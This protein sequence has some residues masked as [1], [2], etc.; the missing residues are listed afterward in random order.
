VIA[1][2]SAGAGIGGLLLGI[3]LILLLLH[4]LEKRRH[5][6]NN[7][8]LR[9]PNIPEMEDEDQNLSLVKWFLRGK[10]RTESAARERRHEIDGRT[11]RVVPG[12]PVEMDASKGL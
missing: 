2:I 8:E 6:R 12:P 4:I 3:G 9:Y 10:W 11:V 1:G 5:G 7:G